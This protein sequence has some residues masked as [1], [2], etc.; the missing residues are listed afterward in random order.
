MTQQK[1]HKNYQIA[2]GTL[3]IIDCLCNQP[4]AN[5]DCPY[6][7]Q[8]SDVYQW[9]LDNF[10]GR[11]VMSH[12]TKKMLHNSGYSDTK[13]LCQAIALLAYRDQKKF[14]TR[15]LKH[16]H[17]L[18]AKCTTQAHGKNYTVSHEGQKYT[19]D[20]H[21]KKGN[22]V[23]PKTCLRIYY[24]KMDDGRIFIGSLPEHL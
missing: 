22:D 4:T 3:S 6:P 14:Y 10:A 8:N 5:D 11:I 17:L 12:R 1:H 7:T 20:R 13:T 23:N 9:V 15:G 2:C 16:L 24:C 18:D 21:L 19:L